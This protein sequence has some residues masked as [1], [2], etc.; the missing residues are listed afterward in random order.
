M[1]F[2]RHSRE[3][4]LGLLLLT[5]AST[6]ELAERLAPSDAPA[7]PDLYRLAVLAVGRSPSGSAPGK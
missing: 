4:L 7:I 5:A 3:A 2:S 6:R 1:L